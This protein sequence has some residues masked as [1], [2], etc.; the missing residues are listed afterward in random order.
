M[1]LPDNAKL[2]GS[3]MENNITSMSAQ[4]CEKGAKG[5]MKKIHKVKDAWFSLKCLRSLYQRREALKGHGG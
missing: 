2:D 4:W 3:C 5:A 1:L